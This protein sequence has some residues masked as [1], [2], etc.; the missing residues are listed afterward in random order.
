MESFLSIY[1]DN[2]RNRVLD[3]LVTFREYDYSMKDIARNARISYTSLKSFW[4]EFAGRQIVLQTRKVGKAK[5]YRLNL[6]SPE[7]KKFVEFYNAVLEME[8]HKL[9]KKRVIEVTA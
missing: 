1:G 3:F 6:A 9:L 7:M 8:T 2:P 4:K 5:M